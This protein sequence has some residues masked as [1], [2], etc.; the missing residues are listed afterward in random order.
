MAGVEVGL[1]MDQESH[2][3]PDPLIVLT[4]P[5]DVGSSKGTAEVVNGVEIPVP[6]NWIS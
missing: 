6:E 1:E 2:D 5:E 3:G 4:L